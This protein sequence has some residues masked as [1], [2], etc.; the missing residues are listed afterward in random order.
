MVDYNK[1]IFSD[2][3]ARDLLQSMERYAAFGVKDKLQVFLDFF[4]VDMQ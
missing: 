4:C 3:D 1:A 2:I